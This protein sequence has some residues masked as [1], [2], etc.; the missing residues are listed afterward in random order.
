MMA[1][2]IKH[3]KRQSRVVRKIKYLTLTETDKIWMPDLFFKNEKTGHFH[4]ILLPNTYI[5]IF[6]NGDVLYS[7]R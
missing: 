1:A 6:P 4:E 7:I 3:E 2:A 5:R